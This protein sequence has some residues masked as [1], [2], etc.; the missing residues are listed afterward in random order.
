VAYSA[1]G[2]S[3]RIYGWVAKGSSDLLVPWSFAAYRQPR[4]KPHDHDLDCVGQCNVAARMGKA[5]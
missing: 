3:G 4:E 1:D 5:Y 2:D